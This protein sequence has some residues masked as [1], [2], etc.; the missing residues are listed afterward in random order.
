MRIGGIK[1][2]VSAVLVLALLAVSVGSVAASP[3]DNNG[4]GPP[5]LS[6]IVSVHYPKGMEAKGG[7]KGP[8]GDKG[9]KGDGGGKA[10]YK[11]GGVHWADSQIP[12]SYVVNLAGS[13]DNGLFLDGLKASFQAWE[14]DAQSYIDFEY[15]GL[16]TGVPSSFI[17]A[18]SMNGSNEVGWTSLSSSFPGAIAVTA[19]WR[20]TDTGEIVEVDAAMSSDLPWSQAA[21]GSGDP[22]SSTGDP[23]AYDVQNIMT[24]EAGH[25]LL[26]GDLYTRKA[27]EQTM[28]GYGS[29]GELK[30]RSL[31][32]GDV[33]G[34]GQIY[35]GAVKP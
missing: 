8:P 3:A 31:E 19:T 5:A 15:G 4:K 6:K 17:G 26:L 27:G 30:K 33:A 20:Y 23:D 29:K 7:G 18:G 24:H 25:W 28:Y 16:F 11:Y 35:P 21:I 22:N 34:I 9:G 14:D 32:S 13:G 10:W 12:V 2:V 1:Y